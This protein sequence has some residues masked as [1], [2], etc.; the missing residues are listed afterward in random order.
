[1][2]KLVR[3]KGERIVIGKDIV[4]EVL[5]AGK[6]VLLGITAPPD[7]PVNREEVLEPIDNAIKRS[8]G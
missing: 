5:R 6:K 4:I 1:M 2:L 3:R 8:E 7:V